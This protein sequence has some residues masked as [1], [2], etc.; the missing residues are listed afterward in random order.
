M[1]VME[2]DRGYTGER[3]RKPLRR[4][5]R[6]TVR[7]RSRASAAYLALAK[8]FPIQPIRSDKELD[9]AI[10]VVDKL[11][12]RRKAL[13]DQEQGYLESL[14]HEIERYESAAYPIPDVSGSA[15]LRHLLDAREATLSDV[16]EAT[17]L[18]L[19]TLSAILNDKRQLTL[20][21]I[22]KLAPYFGVEPGV[23]VME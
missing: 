9:L 16:A 7:R 23:F 8:V 2:P 12:S 21:H 14:S 19:S 4:P 17:G 20:R 3:S 13:S 11:L 15:M 1:T 22:H 5:T 6:G 18:A 10:A